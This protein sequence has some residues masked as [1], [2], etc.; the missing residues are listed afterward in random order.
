MKTKEEAL[1]AKYCRKVARMIPL[2]GVRKRNYLQLLRPTVQEYIIRSGSVNLE[3]IYK[4]YGTPDV[5]A[6]EFFSTMPARDL[7]RKLRFAKRMITI[8][9]ITAFLVLAGTAGTLFHIAQEAEDSRNGYHVI[10]VT[11]YDE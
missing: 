2:N 11:Q 6:E 10:S 1:A 3:Q 9:L 8:A 4:E 7:S 5:Q